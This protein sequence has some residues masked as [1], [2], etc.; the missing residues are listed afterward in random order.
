MNTTKKDRQNNTFLPYRRTQ[1]AQ[2]KD[3][4]WFVGCFV[5][6][7]LAPLKVVTFFYFLKLL[8]NHIPTRWNLTVYLITSQKDSRN[9]V[10]SHGWEEKSNHLFLHCPTAFRVR[11]MVFSWIGVGNNTSPNLFMQLE[12]VIEVVWNKRLKRDIG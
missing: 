11:S 4:I 10:L 5:E 9:C 2:K 12:C 6:K 8:L 3:C 7:S 1:I